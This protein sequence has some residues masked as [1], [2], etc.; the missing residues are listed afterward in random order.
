MVT[1]VSLQITEFDNL[2]LKRT[3]DTTAVR[4]RV[5]EKTQ[6]D[7]DLAEVTTSTNVN[8]TIF[9]MVGNSQGRAPN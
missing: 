5:H 8:G 7:I 9:V 4:Q 6:Q 1:E 3:P 2:L